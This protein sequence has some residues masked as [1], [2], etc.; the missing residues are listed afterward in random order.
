[1][2][3]KKQTE[4]GL[5]PCPSKQSHTCP[6]NWTQA[7]L[8]PQFIHPDYAE[9]QRTVLWLLLGHCNAAVRKE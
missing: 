3:H 9:K 6:F 1:M 5:K 4:H 8:L 7:L 2:Q